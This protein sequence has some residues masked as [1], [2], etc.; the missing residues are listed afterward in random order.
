LK[1][2]RKKLCKRIDYKEELGGNKDSMDT[3]GDK[4]EWMM[5]GRGGRG[6][7]GELE[8][9]QQRNESSKS[10]ELEGITRRQYLFLFLFLFV[11]VVAWDYFGVGIWEFAYTS[12]S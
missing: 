2:R 7:A 3:S 11:F 8:E 4:L 5:M 12:Y 10:A 9:Q 6:A 1:Q